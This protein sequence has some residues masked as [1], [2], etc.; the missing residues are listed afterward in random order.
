MSQG[1][2]P[3]RW[4]KPLPGTIYD[5]KRIDTQKFIEKVTQHFADVDPLT[6]VVLKGHLLLEERLNAT[7]RHSLYNPELLD[8]MKLNFHHKMLF[9]QSFAV[10]KRGAGIWELIAAINALRN[11]IAHSLDEE[12]RR[13]QFQRVRERYLRELENPELRKEDETEPDHLL[14]LKAYA[15]CEGYLLRVEGD[16]EMIGN[17]IRRMIDVMR[18][19]WYAPDQESKVNR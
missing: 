12:Q 9:A 3:R 2:F 19:E 5:V 1:S 11:G 7:L 13:K 15:M 14:F 16:A 18:K 10:S 8:T 6:Q 4:R 17:S